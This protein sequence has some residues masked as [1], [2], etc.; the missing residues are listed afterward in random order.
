MAPDRRPARRPPPLGRAVPAA[1]R[2][3]LPAPPASMTRRGDRAAFVTAV[4]S[5]APALVVLAVRADFYPQC[6]QLAA[7]APALADQV[8]VGPLDRGGLTQAVLGP[9]ERAGLAVQPAG[10]R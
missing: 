1:A 5:A 10:R 8:V 4:T 7:L 6:T 9:A 2:R 3:R